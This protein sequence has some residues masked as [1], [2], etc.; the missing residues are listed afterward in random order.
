MGNGF[1]TVDCIWHVG[2]R[3]LQDQAWGAVVVFGPH[4]HVHPV[5]MLH[6]VVLEGAALLHTVTWRTIC[7]KTRF[8]CTIERT[9]ALKRRERRHAYST[10][11]VGSW[12]VQPFGSCPAVL[13]TV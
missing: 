10:T 5:A 4:N 7:V 13:C 3:A 11:E 2:L 12:S 9:K 1:G 6:D 8:G